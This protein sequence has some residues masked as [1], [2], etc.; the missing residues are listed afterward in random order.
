M[1]TKTAP[2][3]PPTG[4]PRAAALKR[5]VT[6]L[7]LA[8]LLAAFGAVAVTTNP[9]PAPTPPAPTI[10]PAAVQA[11]PRAPAAPRPTA[12]RTAPRSRTRMS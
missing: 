12:R 1:T 6:G 5:R 10:A 2:Q 11:G 9:A 7:S 3:G 4:R 8:V